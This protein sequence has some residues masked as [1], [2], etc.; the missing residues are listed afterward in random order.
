MV[1]LHAAGRTHHV[2]PCV[3]KTRTPQKQGVAATRWPESLFPLIADCHIQQE[4]GDRV[5]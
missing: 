4:F 2:A 5:K 1:Q 3:D